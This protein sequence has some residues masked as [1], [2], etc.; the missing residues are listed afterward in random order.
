[1]IY[2]HLSSTFHFDAVDFLSGVLRAGRRRNLQESLHVTQN[3]HALTAWALSHGCRSIFLA[4]LLPRVHT[5]TLSRVERLDIKYIRVAAISSYSWTLV[6]DVA[7]HRNC[8]CFW[9]CL[10]LQNLTAILIATITVMYR[11]YNVDRFLPTLLMILLEIHW[12]SL[13]SLR[14]TLLSQGKSK[15]HSGSG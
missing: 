10:K 2:E 11:P 3:L 13:S 6:T 8:D 15:F 1:M 4:L 12:T 9:R 14:S 5:K 7:L